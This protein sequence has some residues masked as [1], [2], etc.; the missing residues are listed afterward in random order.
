MIKPNKNKHETPF[1]MVY[2]PVVRAGSQFRYGSRRTL[3]GHP[4]TP[5]RSEGDMLI[6]L[7]QQLVKLVFGSLSEH[8]SLAPFACEGGA[9][10][11]TLGRGE[12]EE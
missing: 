6:G 11:R 9:P 5:C 1:P 3:G 4:V 12:Y 7:T 10:V 8:R 2:L